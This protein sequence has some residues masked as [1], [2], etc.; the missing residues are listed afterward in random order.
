MSYLIL[1]LLPLFA[2][3]T[4]D[5]FVSLDFI[6]SAPYTYNHK[7]GGGAYN[8]RTIGEYADGVESLEGK[9]ETCFDYV[10]YLL[11]IV[12][13]PN[14]VDT[15]NRGKF[16]M[17]FLADA[18]G[19]PGVA[20]GVLK[21]VYVNGPG[22][23]ENG[24]G[25]GSKAGVG[26]GKFAVDGLWID[27]GTPAKIEYNTSVLT[28]PLFTAG[29]ELVV[30]WEISGLNGGDTIPVRIDVQLLCQIGSHPTGNLQAAMTS[31]QC[32]TKPNAITDIPGGQ[33]TVPFKTVSAIHGLTACIP[34]DA[35]APLKGVNFTADVNVY[36]PKVQTNGGYST[37]KFYYSWSSAAY[38][39]TNPKTGVNTLH[40]YDTVCT[41]LHQG[42]YLYSQG[43]CG[44]ESTWID[45]AQPQL[46]YDPNGKYYLSP[47][48]QETLNA[49]PVLKYTADNSL[50]TKAIQTLYL[51]TTTPSVVVRAIWADGTVIDFFNVNLAPVPPETFADPGV[52][53]GCKRRLDIAILVDKSVYIT[54]DGYTAEKQFATNLANQFS[55][56]PNN[57]QFALFEFDDTVI[58]QLSINDGTTTTNVLNKIS[59][60]QCKLTQ[61]KCGSTSP[62][63][64]AAINA[65]V[66]NLKTSTRLSVATPA[67]VV[68]TT[69][70][71]STQSNSLT[72]AVNAAR[73]A[74]ITVFVVTYNAIVTPDQ[75]YSAF[76]GS[77]YVLQR[78]DNLDLAGTT[79]DDVAS[80]VC[81]LNTKPCGDFCCGVCDTACSTCLPVDSC[82]GGVP[83]CVNET[84][85][86]GACCVNRNKIN[87]CVPPT[88][89][90]Q[91]STCNMVTGLCENKN[92]CV[93]PPGDNC[94]NYAC[95]NGGC[96]KT[97]NQVGSV[98][99]TITCENNAIK[100]TPV[101]CGTPN[102]C[103][104]VSCDV[105]KGGCIVT[106]KADTSSGTVDP[107][108][109][110]VC[111]TTSGWINKPVDCPT[112]DP[113][114]PRSCVNGVCQTTPV[115]CKDPANLCDT[116]TCVNGACVPSTKTCTPGP[117]QTVDPTFASSCNPT[118]GNCVFK[119][120]ICQSGTC[121][122]QQCNT[123]TNKC[124]DVLTPG[125]NTNCVC[126]NS[127]CSKMLCN[128][129]NVCQ[130]PIL[131]N[132]TALAPDY[133]TL[134]NPCDDTLGCTF[135]PIDCSTK[136]PPTDKCKYLVAD[137]TAPGC[138]VQKDMVCNK[139]NPCKTYGCDPATGCTEVDKCVQT[140]D[141]CKIPS[142]SS[143]GCIDTVVQCTPPDAC[144]TGTCDSSTGNCAYQAMKCDDN[145]ACTTDSCENGQC[146]HVTLDCTDND[147]CTVNSCVNGACT[148][149]PLPCD[150]SVACT[151]DSCDP[152]TGC[153]H[154]PDNSFCSS[155]DPCVTL[156]CHAT[157]G[158]V[159]Q[160]VTCPN[161]GKRCLVSSCVPYEGCSN[162]SVTCNSTDPAPCVFTHCEEDKEKSQDKCQTVVLTCAA[163]V[164]NT[165]VVAAAAATS[166]AVIAGIIAAVV[167]CGGVAGGAAVAI[168]RRGDDGS[169]NNIANNPLY[170]STNNAADNPLFH[171]N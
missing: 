79:P 165:I 136:P 105:T 45:D 106:P 110:R 133:C 15:E 43:T 28:G 80:K 148:T 38:F 39:I 144:Y 69:G 5:D 91:V 145:N 141:K 169:M 18:T 99:E 124:V 132:C 11:A 98:C 119:S 134:A 78:F 121:M 116:S 85:V 96:Q 86:S 31:S 97:L 143:T 13:K 93:A 102:A 73:S 60:L 16:V 139:G 118:T 68:V 49:Q 101:T 122:N 54:S 100:R 89:T 82:N 130:S 63:P 147:A 81:K 74:G 161:T 7:V 155:P 23:V 61:K 160:N 1:L 65:A 128:A 59:A 151:L 111:D 109:P 140:T 84:V 158:C 48:V 6:A 14:P 40:T 8:D 163:P 135:T 9:Q 104:S 67:I 112:T 62:N 103:Q 87:A 64:A 29:S 24:N 92:T 25:G 2:F 34:G 77:Y 154:T 149:T 88:G 95:V 55:I 10:S 75:Q 164:D 33:Q 46:F 51:S 138:C 22:P 157:K 52:D 83:N 150:D 131:T 167:I 117:C 170:I 17:S 142:C 76:G 41:Y 114:N 156:T 35:I 12:M 20:L 113:C 153:K 3:A 4:N 21:G 166:A 90:C 72:T 50:G 146:K 129:N 58:Q 162:S 27:K 107:C 47:P 32:S 171:N 37:S 19:Q 57:A 30:T 94:Y 26:A 123:Q 137:P 53:C 126:T 168:A 42:E 120:V 115:I 70:W 66:T 108:N 56:G 71:E 159:S 127:K 36:N 125:C 152:I 44:C